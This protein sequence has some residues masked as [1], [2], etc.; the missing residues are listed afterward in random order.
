MQS[1]GAIGARPP[2]AVIRLQG[3]GAVV[4]PALARSVQVFLANTSLVCMASKALLARP[5]Q[6]TKK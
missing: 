3:A 2:D 4:S 1:G 5:R 6:L